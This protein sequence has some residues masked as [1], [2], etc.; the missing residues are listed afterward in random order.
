MGRKVTRLQHGGDTSNFHNGIEAGYAMVQNHGQLS[1][2]E[3]LRNSMI[4]LASSKLR[5]PLSAEEINHIELHL[6][7]FFHAFQTPNHPSYSE[8]IYEAME[9]SDKDGGSGSSIDSISSYIVSHY[10]DLP[11]AHEQILSTHLG[12]LVSSGEIMTNP[13]GSYS[14]P[15]N[16]KTPQLLLEHPCLGIDVTD[17][18]GDSLAIIARD[19]VETHKL[20]CKGERTKKLK[21][22]KKVVNMKK[23]K[24]QESKGKTEEM[25]K[26]AK[27]TK[28]R[29]KGKP[30]KMNNMDHEGGR[31]MLRGKG[32]WKL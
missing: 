31:Y 9:A 30:Q 4:E 26:E 15:K 14:F 7:K 16:M 12:K 5:H 13:N 1:F 20:V 27:H 11:W 28:Q 29:G 3:K 25:A 21:S 6:P 18:G 23:R 32:K 19:D 24:R 10:Q 22:R 2:M 8:M 17:P